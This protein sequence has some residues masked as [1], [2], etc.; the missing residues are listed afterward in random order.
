MAKL[1]TTPEESLMKILDIAMSDP[2]TYL[3]VRVYLKNHLEGVVRKFSSVYSRDRAEKFTNNL[4]P[5]L[6]NYICKLTN[7]N[8]VQNQW[9]KINEKYESVVLSN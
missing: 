6:A 2:S 8:Y 3:D 1:R 7:K 5:M 4:F 9:S